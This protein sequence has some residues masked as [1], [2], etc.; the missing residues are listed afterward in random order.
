MTKICTNCGKTVE[1]R[2]KFC[3]YCRS[4]SF[5]NKYEVIEADNSPVHRLFYWNYDGRYAISKSKVAGIVTFLTFSLTAINFGPAMIVFAFG[6]GALIFILGLDI[7]Q[8][9]SRPSPT[10]LEHN[11]YGLLTDLKHFF[12][13]WQNNE[14]QYVLSKTKLCCHFIFLMFFALAM[15][16]PTTALGIGIMVGMFFEA[17]VY[18]LGYGIHKI[19]NPN[20][21]A[22]EGYIEPSKQPSKIK[23]PKMTKP[24]ALKSS[25][26][27]EYMGYITQ[28]DDLNSKFKSKEK[29]TRKLIEKRFEPPQLTYTRFINGVDKSAELFKKQ[30][31]AAYSMINLADEYSPRIAGEIESKIDILTSITEKLDNLANELVLTEDESRKEDVETVFDDMDALI[32]SVKDYDQ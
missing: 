32:N 23:L 5:K 13:Y 30:S 21:Q 12:L 6:F 18:L 11:D 15:A 7:H 4:T 1:D 8:F 9:L 20:P 31:D 26:I 24:K 28:L 19:T 17:P 27:P 14:G 2:D 10:K 16:T 29:S 3:P 22:P 25:I